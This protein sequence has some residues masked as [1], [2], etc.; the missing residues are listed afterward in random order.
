MTISIVKLGWQTLTQPIS[1]NDSNSGMAF[2]L[3][4]AEGITIHGLD[5][6]TG[7]PLP[8]ILALFLAP[9]GSIAFE[10]PINLD[11]TGRGEI[12]QLA[13][14]V[15]TAYFFGRDYAPLPL[16]SVQ[17]PSPP[18][19]VAMTQGGS[20]DIRSSAANAGAGAA[21]TTV[22]G[23]PYL[24]SPVR[25]D[26]NFSLA[27]TLTSFAHVAP[28]AYTLTVN[29]STGPEVYAVQIGVGQTTTVA[30]P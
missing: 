12:P 23:L 21:L 7:I 6:Q 19:T 29:R 3:T 20:L 11:A 24:W 18:I 4:R 16:G 13:P 30:V 25:F 15:D 2:Q 14:G 1:V 17:I 26:P 8:Q 27:G 10:G 5:G 28:G 9:G 22:S